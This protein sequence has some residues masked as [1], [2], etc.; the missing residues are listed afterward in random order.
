M[1][2]L[3]FNQQFTLAKDSETGPLILD[4]LA[5]S[6]IPNIVSLVAKNPNTSELT[7]YKILN[8]EIANKSDFIVVALTENPKASNWFLKDL[9]KRTEKARIHIMIAAETRK[10]FLL[11]ELFEKNYFSIQSRVLLNPA[12]PIRLFEQ[13]VDPDLQRLICEDCNTP[14][15]VLRRLVGKFPQAINHPNYTNDISSTIERLEY[16]RLYDE[17]SESRDI[18][19]EIGYSKTSKYL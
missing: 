11:K 12:C 4:R 18:L 13:I 1:E 6:E 19:F 16:S 14:S 3:R 2:T 9:I 7:L 15:W 17:Q 8:S 10:H 5:D